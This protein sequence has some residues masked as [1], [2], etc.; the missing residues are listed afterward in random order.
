MT[1]ENTYKKNEIVW[2]SILQ[3]LSIFLV[4]LGHVRHG[5]HGGYYWEIG[6]YNFFFCFRM[7]L[8]MFTS[9]FLYYYTAIGKKKRFAD[10]VRR[11]STQLLIPYFLF[12]ALSIP[13]KILFSKQ[14]VRP[15]EFSF[16]YLL[17]AFVWLT[18]M[19]LWGFWFINVLYFLFMIYPI[20]S[21]LDSS[22]L[23]E[24]LF[25]GYL[26]IM[27]F[28]CSNVGSFVFVFG[29]IAFYGVFFYSGILASKYLSKD[30]KNSGLLLV[31]WAISF[32]FAYFCSLHSS[33]FSAIVAFFG[34]ATAV[35]AAKL[36]SIY[37]PML[38]SSYRNY[39]YQIF[40]FGIFVQIGLRTIVGG[41][42]FSMGTKTLV[43]YVSSVSLAIYIPV[44]ISRL[45][46]IFPASTY[47][48]FVKYSIGMR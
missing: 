41:L 32:L 38:F 6:I 5:G 46:E 18:N 45:V 25:W 30:T 21:K 10:V 34:I 36:I 29:K 14:V 22:P 47:S 48:R 43:L 31:F 12:N 3:G 13:V 33:L 44:A 11:K 19:P 26:V 4:L 27:H 24:V 23:F 28:Y 39:T 37:C 15:S 20:Y 42:S 17:D 40:L 2:L 7:E 16:N 35:N 8:F 1:N 9:G